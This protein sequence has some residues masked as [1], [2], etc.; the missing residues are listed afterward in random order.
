MSLP[1]PL[2]P[3]TQVS[4]EYARLLLLELSTGGIIVGTLRETRVR[5]II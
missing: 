5:V 3:I 2:R 1:Y 4:G